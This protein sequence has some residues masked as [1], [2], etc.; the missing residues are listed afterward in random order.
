MATESTKSLWYQGA[1]THFKMT[2]K[3]NSTNKII[4]Q[5]SQS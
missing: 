1:K 4:N 3:I 2:S 5:S